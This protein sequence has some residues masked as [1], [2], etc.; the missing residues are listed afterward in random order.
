MSNVSTIA[1]AL[2]TSQKNK[3]VCLCGKVKL[4]NQGEDSLS[5]VTL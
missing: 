1:K 4:L 5:E 2:L 3:Q